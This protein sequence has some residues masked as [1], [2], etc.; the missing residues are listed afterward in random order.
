MKRI[1]FAAFFSLAFLTLSAVAKEPIRLA[2][3]DGGHP[4]DAPA[5]DALLAETAKSIDGG[6]KIERFHF[7]ADRDKLGPELA[8]SFDVI[9]FYD[10]DNT[11]LSDEQKNRIEALF[12]R[13]I[14]IFALHHHVCSN[15]NWPDYWKYIGGIAVFESNKMI[16]GQERE[17]STF[18]D[19]QTLDVKIEPNS[20]LFWGIK[21]FTI[22]DEAYGKCYVDPKAKIL[23]TSDHPLSTHAIAWQWRYGRSDVLA[24]LLGHDAKSY[25]IP[26]F[27]LI[28]R[29]GIEYLA[30]HKTVE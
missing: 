18:I 4:F 23:A 25:A 16:D 1:F 29:Q 3:F 14:G 7:P 2:V 17:L 9:L 8:D 26:E 12:Q 10:M 24:L 5:F 6:A 20:G 13:G 30:H 11:P 28:L 22:Q 19:R 27:K 21:N 15:Q